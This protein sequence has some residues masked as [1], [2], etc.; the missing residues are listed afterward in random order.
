VSGWR[1]FLRKAR[2]EDRLDAELRFHLERQVEGYV[3]A[4]MTEADARR[5]ARLEF[6][7][8]EQ[9]KEDCRDARPT[10]WVESTVRDFRSACR[11]LRKSP[12]F[13][14]AAIATLA[15]GIG[16]NTSIFSVVNAVFLRPLP[17]PNPGR[18]VAPTEYYPNFNRSIALTPE[19]G[20]WQQSGV[21]EHLEGMFT[22]AGVTWAA[23]GEPAERVPCT[24]VTPGFFAMLGIQPQ[25]GPGFS[26]G[27]ATATSGAVVVSDALWRNYFHSDPALI[28]KTATANGAPVT[29][30]GIMPAGFLS[31]EAA[32]TAIWLPDA[33]PPGSTTPSRSVRYVNAIGRLKDGVPIETA[34]AS[35]EII[36]R[37]MD[38][39]YPTPWSGYHANAHV[40]VV[41]LRDWITVDSKLGLYV[42]MGAVGFILL[43]ACANVANLFLAHAAA[44]EKEM[45]I[46]AA[47]GAS[48]GR[49]LRLLLMESFLVAA[50]GALLG[51]PF[52]YGGTRLLRFLMPSVLSGRVSLDWR[53]LVFAILCSL[54]ASLLFGLLPALTA[55]R[56]DLTSRLKEGG[57]RAG[58]DRRGARLR[59]TLAVVQL[60][61]SVVL[62]AGA[63]LMFRSF[64]LLLNVPP[65][66]DSHQTLVGDI[67]LAPVALYTPP[68]QAAFFHQALDAIS[69]LPGV[70]Y[71]AFTSSSPLATFNIIG[72]GLH[73]EGEPEEAEAVAITSA[74]ADYFRALRVPLLAGR[75]FNQGDIAGT[76]RVA[77]LNQSLARILFKGGDAVGR[78]V[79]TTDGKDTWVTVVGIVADIRHRSLDEK[80]WPEVFYPYEQAPTPWMSP[81]IRGR[82]DPSALAPA[83]RQ[84]VQA[85]DRNQPVFGLELLDQRLSNSVAQRRERAGLLGCF[86]LVALLIAVVG[87]YGV[88]AYSVTRRTHEIGVRIA[89]GAQK[90][91]V[92]RM[93][94]AEGLRLAIAGLTMGVIGAL[95][96]TRVLASFL[97]GVNPRDPATFV[98]VCIALATAALLAT[99]IPARRAARVD[100][101]AALRHE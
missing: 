19:F 97:F 28:G 77:I 63:G 41:S 73:A 14:A 30:V 72:A 23:S 88:I 43:I 101:I 99:Y 75:F 59:A 38:S 37:Q 45:A 33:A 56:M 46:R 68:R 6:G 35:L 32:N 21:F 52:L 49:L 92:L 11:T 78:K 79:H 91:D 98:S 16:A 20:A 51:T 27:Y 2:L 61:L 5:R 17:Y 54:A 76:P 95:A 18:L 44:R 86:A 26:D 24:H 82:G 85:I 62:L 22:G 34:R 83:I 58:L 57:A 12:A 84:A 40:R 31:P 48:R 7:G 42:L 39:R 60:A 80:I 96:L 70:E 87:V 65:G 36:A 10:V 89:L 93:M 94:V 69:A 15:L 66:F 55:S 67:S 9:V 100:P 90:Q 64:V 4:G 25:A 53:V 1:R 3:R 29:I 71:A 47:T 50:L 81:L 13:A 74:S 8:L